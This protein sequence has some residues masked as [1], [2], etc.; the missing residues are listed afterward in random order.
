MDSPAVEEGET[1]PLLFENKTEF[2]ALRY[3]K[4]KYLLLCKDEI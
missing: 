1:M 4:D 3:Y 2:L